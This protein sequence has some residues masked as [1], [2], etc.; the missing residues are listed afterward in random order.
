MVTYGK[1]T[2]HKVV[3]CNISNSNSI[4]TFRY[5]SYKNTGVPL[6]AIRQTYA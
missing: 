5:C 2:Y 3:I 1:K 4:I 6:Q